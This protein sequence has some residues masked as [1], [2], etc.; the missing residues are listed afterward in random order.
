MAD[1]WTINLHDFCARGE[2]REGVF[3]AADLPRVLEEASGLGE[4]RWAIAGGAV[5]RS[6]SVDHVGR[7]SLH[8]TISGRLAV[9]CVRC[10]TPLDIDLDIRQ[11]FIVFPSEA[12]ADEALVEDE[13]FDA[14][15]D[16]TDFDL[17]ALIED[18]ILM[19]IP[20]RAAHET[21]SAQ[22]LAALGL[23]QLGEGVGL[24]TPRE[25]PFDV[26]KA[27]KDQALKKH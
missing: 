4:I 1:A 14:I 26:L 15:A 22:A 6:E 18:E 23:A 2:Q 5:K 8:L 24:H 21:C 7:P 3:G 12:Q 13:A 10:L 16:S 27:L 20:P 25:N 11:G 9:P 19:A 17:A